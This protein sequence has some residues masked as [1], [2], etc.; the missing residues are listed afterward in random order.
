MFQNETVKWADP[1]LPPFLGFLL[2]SLFHVCVATAVINKLEAISQET[3]GFVSNHSQISSGEL[4]Q[5]TRTVSGMFL[6][7]AGNGEKRQP[8]AGTGRG[9]RQ[10]K[11]GG[12]ENIL[13]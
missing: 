5:Q 8:C 3:K 1:P 6:R 2:H 10:E 12:L 4:E 9:F 11:G 13:A 7:A